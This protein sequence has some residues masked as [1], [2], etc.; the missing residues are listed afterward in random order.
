M[1][2]DLRSSWTRALGST[3][4]QGYQRAGLLT[5]E[6]LTLIKRVDRQP[7]GKVESILVTSGQ[8]YAQLYLKL[9]KKLARV[10]T[11][12]WLLVVITDALAGILLVDL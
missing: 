10:D 8:T 1:G 11:L 6:E 7:R 5:S 3:S 9:L 12:Q 4:V 2:G